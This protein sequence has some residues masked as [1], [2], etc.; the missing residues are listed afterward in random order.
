VKT[1]RIMRSTEWRRASDDDND[2]EA[3]R[4]ERSLIGA[5]EEKPGDGERALIEATLAK[6]DT[7]LNLL[8]SASPG[9]PT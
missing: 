5:A 7:A 1:D 8:D 2:R 4:T 9:E 6:I 3:S